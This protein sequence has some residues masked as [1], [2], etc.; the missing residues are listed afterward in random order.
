MGFS[1]NKLSHL[2]SVYFKW[3]TAG[4]ALPVQTLCQQNIARGVLLTGAKWGG[5]AFVPSDD[6]STEFFVGGH[7]VCCVFFAA[8]EAAR[9]RQ[10]I[11]FPSLFVPEYKKNTQACRWQCFLCSCVSLLWP[12]FQPVL[13]M[14]PSTTAVS[15]MRGL[16]KKDK[17][18]RKHINK[19]KLPD[20]KDSPLNLSCHSPK[21]YILY[22]FSNHSK[23]LIVI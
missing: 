23:W 5:E 16:I 1:H 2:H 10:G 9:G 13:L 19:I 18:Q 21:K 20:D 7:T 14:A 15:L 4:T 3:G 22:I 8:V 12:G 17:S 6:T 11:C